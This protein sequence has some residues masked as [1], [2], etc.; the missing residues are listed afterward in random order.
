MPRAAK[1]LALAIGAELRRRADQTAPSAF[2]E[3][4]APR[5]DQRFVRK[6]AMALHKSATTGGNTTDASWGHMLTGTALGSMIEDLPPTSALAQL[7]NGLAHQIDF[8][9]QNAVVHP[10][11]MRDHLAADWVTEGGMIPVKQGMIGTAVLN[12]F[13]VGVISTITE[14]VKRVSA[15][16]LVATIE[17]SILADSAAALDGFFFDAEPATAHVRPA[18]MMN[19]AT[20]QASAGASVEQINTDLKWLLQQML[21][22]RAR[23]P[24]LV[25][26]PLTVAAL[27]MVTTTGTGV[28]AFKADIAAGKLAGLLFITSDLADPT[29]V[30]AMDADSVF[31]GLDL[32]EFDTSNEAMLVL[33]DDPET[34]EGTV[35]TRSMFQT[36]TSAVRFIQPVSWGTTR[37]GAVVAITGV[38]Y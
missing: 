26:H 33:S 17:G 19:G 38:D 7:S 35:Q 15:V 30:V 36:W 2:I 13:K 21:A 6:A 24:V 32:P 5:D 4:A 1:C 18:G 9:G 34:D 23:K 10:R 37:S 29:Q 22:I 8:D 27:S 31:I 20:T 12:R 3:Q 28:Y 25:L 14:D 11:W 16:D